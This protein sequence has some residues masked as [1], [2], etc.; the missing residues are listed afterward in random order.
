M[1]APSCFDSSRRFA[2][3]CIQCWIVLLLFRKDLWCSSG[4]LS[5]IVCQVLFM[6]CTVQFFLGRPTL[7]V[8]DMFGLA[9]LPLNVAFL[10]GA[11]GSSRRVW[12]NSVVCACFTC[13][14]MFCVLSLALAFSLFGHRKSAALCLTS[15]FV[16]ALSMYVVC[17]FSICLSPFSWNVSSFLSCVLVRNIVS[18]A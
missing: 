17:M 12:A 4:M 2:A 1:V 16:F 6:S 5:L 3:S 18:S 8:L 13:L 11:V 9:L 10:V 15:L 7:L 14:E